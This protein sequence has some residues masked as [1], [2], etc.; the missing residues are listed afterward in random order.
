MWP[1]AA[2][3]L[4]TGAMAIE[5]GV[6]WISAHGRQR[7]RW[8]ARAVE[9]LRRGDTAAAESL[10]AADGS[11]YAWYVGE[12]VTTRGDESLALERA[13]RLRPRIERFSAVLSVIITAAPMLGILGTVA[14]IIASFDALGIGAADGGAVDPGDV[15]TGISEALYTTAAGLVVALIALLPYALSRRA[16]ERALTRLELLASAAQRGLAK[17]S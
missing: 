2:I 16:A 1:L 7:T 15:A 11:M 13:E 9:A 3:S 14:G 6:F 17:K 12:L 10:A 5:R 8:V 4:A